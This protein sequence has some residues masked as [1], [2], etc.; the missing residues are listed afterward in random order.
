MT[1]PPSYGTGKQR[2]A[3]LPL[4]FIL[5]LH[6]VLLMLWSSGARMHAGQQAGQRRVLLAWLPPLTPQAKPAPAP[7]PPQ[8]VAPRPVMTR[9]TAASKPPRP[10]PVH[11]PEAISAEADTPQQSSAPPVEH[12]EP[13]D[14]RHMIDNAKRQAGMIDR[15]LRA[16]KPSPLA[17]DP[18]L[19]IAR[20]QSALENAYIDRSRTTVTDSYTQADGVIVYRF[21]QG[22]KVWCRQSGGAGPS[23]LERSEGAK[24]AGAGSRG[25]AGAAGNVTCPSGASWSRR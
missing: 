20:F 17:P 4:A 22:G 7:A 11:V 1:I 25:G 6:L 23:L 14:V 13:T 5:V 16:G 21:R 18:N 9:A 10:V 12:R 19:P 15:E 8:K 2:I 3:L 24:L